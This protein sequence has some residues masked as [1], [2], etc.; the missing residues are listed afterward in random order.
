MSSWN[1]TSKVGQRPHRERSQPENRQHLGLL[2]KK[3]DYKKRAVDF[4]TKQNVIK[5]LKRKTLDKNPEEYYFNMINTRLKNGVHSLK[6]KYKHYDD[7]QLKLMQS[8]D[9][10]YIKYK[11]QIERKKIEKLQTTTHLIDESYRQPKSHIFFV[12]SERELKKFDPVK[13]LKTHPLLI[14]QISNRLT[15]DQLKTMSDLSENI[16]EKELNKSRKSRKKK[17]VELQ[18]RLEREKKLRQVET[19]MEEKIV[20][21]NKKEDDDDLFS[22]DDE[23]KAEKKAKK[24]SKIII[25]RKK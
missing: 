17:Y 2:E 4:Q 7:D 15:L 22:G 21:K 9:L 20:L 25:P 6:K 10:R 3:K 5:E 8:Q 24:Q 11:H 12:D 14:N 16:D 19:T 23:D 18:K 13:Q 1:K